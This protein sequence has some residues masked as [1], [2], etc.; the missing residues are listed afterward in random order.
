MAAR[1]VEAMRRRQ[2]QGPYRLGGW[3]LGAIVA[4]EM[5][6]L[7]HEAGEK[8]ELLALLDSHPPLAPGQDVPAL[9]DDDALLARWAGELG[10]ADTG[11]VLER[12]RELRLL[13]ASAGPDDLKRGLRV[14]RAHRQAVLSYRVSDPYPGR[15]TLF[16]G[17]AGEG[18]L[19][20]GRLSA[21]PVEVRPVPGGHYGIL[22]EPHVRALAEALEERLQ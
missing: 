5:A 1:Y 2:P 9:E 15:L 10:V 21:Q 18:D 7:L 17:D 13:P 16:R 12:L 8:T 20:W 22:A 14:Y 3:S 11:G 4:F 19:G 6:R